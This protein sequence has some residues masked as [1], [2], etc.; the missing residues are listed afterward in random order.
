MKS[1]YQVTRNKKRLTIYLLKLSTRGEVVQMDLR[2]LISDIYCETGEVFAKTEFG[3]VFESFLI[4][5]A[6]ELCNPLDKTTGCGVGYDSQ[7]GI[8]S[9]DIHKPIV[10]I[11]IPSLADQRN[12]DQNLFPGNIFT[13]CTILPTIKPLPCIKKKILVKF[14]R[15]FGDIN[16]RN[17]WPKNINY[18]RFEVKTSQDDSTNYGICD[19][20]K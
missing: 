6:D 7:K 3:V 15:D 1:Q 11:L 16:M 4:V 19:I 2:Q 17:H 18:D 13:I 9:S 5:D 14:R 20:I 8:C 10:P 12:M